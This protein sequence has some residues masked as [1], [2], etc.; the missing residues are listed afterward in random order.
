MMLGCISA[1]C[2]IAFTIRKCASS[3]KR[4]PVTAQ[5]IEELSLEPYRPMLRLLDPD[6]FELLRSQ[7]GCTPE[8]IAKMRRERC[9]IFRGYLA[10]LREDFGH[11]CLA[12]KLLMA[13]ANDDR[14]DL[15]RI[16]MR[17]RLRFAAGVVLVQLR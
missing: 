14:P 3:S 1:A 9:R 2:G 7:P 5:G 6:E 16:L 12:L 11:V 13:H 17:S 15:A 4:L 10:S 8:T